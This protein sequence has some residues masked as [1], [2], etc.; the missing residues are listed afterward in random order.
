MDFPLLLDGQRFQDQGTVLGTT[1]ATLLTHSGTAHVKGAYTQLVASTPFAAAGIMVQFAS[2]TAG[3]AQSFL[4]DL[5]MGA[6]AAEQVIIANLLLE[7]ASNAGTLQG[8]VWIPFTIPPG[9]RLAAR[10]QNNA[11]S[12]TIAV[13]VILLASGLAGMPTG[14]RCLTMGIDTATSLGAIIDPGA[15]V[16]VKGAYTELTSSA[17]HEVRTLLFAIGANLNT[18]GS[19][20]RWFLDIA[21]GAAA[22]E[23]VYLPNLL[24]SVAAAARSPL[25]SWI[26]PIPVSVPAGTRIVARAQCNTPDPTDRKFT[27]AAY[28]IG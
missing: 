21:I 12:G 22:G 7:T 19:V 24:F 1:Q 18:A 2:G 6:A 17:A 14:G 20:A 27:L 4:V 28:G 13:G 16:N 26:G 10:Q 25:P 3:T 23:T 11:V 9:V 15:T 5:A 8:C